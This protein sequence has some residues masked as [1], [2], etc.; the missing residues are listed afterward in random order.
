MPCRVALPLTISESVITQQTDLDRV[1]SDLNGIVGLDTEFHR[2]R[3]FFPQPCVLQ[4]TTSS[5]AFIVDLFAPLNLAWLEAALFKEN[6]VKVM[7]AP[8]EDLE[9]FHLIFG[10][11]LPNF[12]DVQLAHAFVS[13]NPSMNYSALVDFYLDVPLQQNKKLTQSDWRTRPLAPTQIEYALDDVRFLVPLWDEIRSRLV[14]SNRLSWFLEE[15][16]YSFKSVYEFSLL[17]LSAIPSQL[18]W[19]QIEIQVYF[20][21]LEWRERTARSRNLPR[22]RVLSNKRL[23]LV[24][25]HCDE[26]IAFFEEQ[27]RGWGRSLHRLVARIKKGNFRP[28]HLNY[29][30][31]RN[32]YRKTRELFHRSKEPIKQLVAQ[33]SEDLNLA[34]GLL[35]SGN[36]ISTWISHY[37]EQ[38]EFPPSFGAW[39]EEVLGKELRELLNS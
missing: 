4:I 16:Q 27:F 21:L 36:Q 1:V 15:V 17:D 6:C 26:D 9:L 35:G 8:R 2:R 25:E 34:S 20:G 29:H 39:R 31:G 19:E 5:G 7:H 32:R 23:R 10:A 30:C 28:K 22:E 37:D 24:V 18:D 3:T 38:R 11:K 12:V 14:C 13:S 33:K